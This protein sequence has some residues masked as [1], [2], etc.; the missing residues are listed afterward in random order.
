MAG[1]WPYFGFWY[2]FQSI[3]CLSSGWL[4][5][6]D[7]SAASLP[8]TFEDLCDS[9]MLASRPWENTDGELRASGFTLSL[10][11]KDME[12]DW[13][14][15]LHGRVLTSFL[16]YPRGPLISPTTLNLM[17]IRHAL[18]DGGSSINFYGEGFQMLSQTGGTLDEQYDLGM[19]TDKVTPQNPHFKI[20]FCETRRQSDAAKRQDHYRIPAPPGARTVYSLMLLSRPGA[21]PLHLL[22][23]FS[24][25]HRLAGRFTISPGRIDAAIDLDPA[26][27]PPPAAAGGAPVELEELVVLAGTARGPLLARLASRLNRNHPP[28]PLARLSPPPLPL[29][30][31]VSSLPPVTPAAASGPG[32]DW[33][34]TGWCSWYVRVR[35]C[36]RICPPLPL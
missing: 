24:S 36:V 5:W 6:E 7:G 18:H 8:H 25:S 11:W 27:A 9:I 14:G 30:P 21:Q 22:L 10:E 2:I 19:F 20:P 16:T 15:G 1:S 23:A 33:P 4:R 28:L 32:P 34:P 29:P 13:K 31:P 26:V 3:W 12:V 35:V 17:S